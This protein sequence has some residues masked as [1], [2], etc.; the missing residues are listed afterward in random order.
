MYQ[1][2]RVIFYYGI[3]PLHMGAGSAT[4]AI[5]NPIQREVH[6]G[7]PLIAGSGIK[8]AIR[9]H[10]IASGI[11]NEEDRA[12][13]FGPDTKASDFAGAVSFTDAQIVAFPVRSLRETFVYATSPSSLARLKRIAG[14]AASWEVP[15]VA[16][17]QFLGDAK[18][19]LRTGDG[20]LIL[21]VFEF[22]QAQQ[23]IDAIAKWIAESALP[24]GDEHAFFRTKIQQ[25]LIVLNDTD[26]SH[27]V[28]N[29]TVV[30]PHVRI[31]NETGTADAN[32]GGL[33]Y[34]ENL[35]PESLLVGQVLSTVDRS[36][37]K[38]T[39]RLLD[40]TKILA[41]LLEGRDAKP[42]IDNSVIQFGG[43]ATSGRGLVLVHSVKGGN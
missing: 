27:F 42:G 39:S 37:G 36:K 3:S 16:Q 25:D 10:F 40:A 11:L 13:I 12:V 7:H 8:G 26:F 43:D 17:G 2:K 20:K 29:A 24:V 32:N 14:A 28:Q 23:C 34:T 6:T 41:L 18:N 33:F 1:E 38:D 15:S 19:R 21:E 5:D 35:P 22:A 31:N 9:H 30:E 4:G